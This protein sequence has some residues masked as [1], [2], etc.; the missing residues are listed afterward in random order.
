[1]ILEN[2]S[3]D[4][5]DA[6]WFEN[7]V[8]LDP[9]LAEYQITYNVLSSTI[10]SPCSSAFKMGTMKDKVLPE[11]LAA[12]IRRLNF[13]RSGLTVISRVYDWTLVG[14]VLPSS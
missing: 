7:L 4:D 8:L 10:E 6:L 11:P 13:L 9:P 2:V 3:L 12:R 5:D 14:V 1:L